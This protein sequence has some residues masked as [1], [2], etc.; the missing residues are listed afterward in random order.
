MRNYIAQYLLANNDKYE[1]NPADVALVDVAPAVDLV[2]DDDTMVTGK[3]LREN[4]M[5][6]LLQRY[7]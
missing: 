5:E 6:S 1:F 7:Q 3:I 4:L 2:A